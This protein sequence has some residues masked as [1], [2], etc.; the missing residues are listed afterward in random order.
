MDAGGMM[1]M[2]CPFGIVT[3]TSYLIA[4]VCESDFVVVGDLKAR[5]PARRHLRARRA[6][7]SN[8]EQD[9]QYYPVLE[10]CTT[11]LECGP[12]KNHSTIKSMNQ[13][14]VHLHAKIIL[15]KQ[16]DYAYAKRYDM[17]CTVHS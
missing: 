3:R 17:Y 11:V 12:S 13:P 6:V 15:S 5:S 16:V 2:L 9:V 10:Y 14:K 1:L 4:F 8:R 7:F